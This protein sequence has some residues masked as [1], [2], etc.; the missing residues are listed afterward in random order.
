MEHFRSLVLRFVGDKDHSKI[1]DIV[2][3]VEKVAKT[4]TLDN[5]KRVAYRGNPQNNYT[6]Q[7]RSSSI[8]CYNCNQWGHRAA[9]CRNRRGHQAQTRNSNAWALNVI[10]ENLKS[11]NIW[12]Y[13]INLWVTEL[14]RFL[15]K[16]TKKKSSLRLQGAPVLKRGTLTPS[17][18][19]RVRTVLPC[20]L[21][22]V[23]LL[24]CYDGQ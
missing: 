8:R 18:L 3:K 6:P 15:M 17:R 11:E 10:S 14:L 16:L 21:C 9:R 22:G 24:L 1:F 5:E 2:A 19:Y 7:S 4:A 20:G 13:W 12:K 23:Y